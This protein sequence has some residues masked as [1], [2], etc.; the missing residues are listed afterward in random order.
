MGRVFRVVFIISFFLLLAT[1]ASAGPYMSWGQWT[2]GNGDAFSRCWNRAGGALQSV[3]LTP[4][5]NGRF[6]HGSN[7]VF[8]A[9]VICYDLGNRFIVTITVAAE[10]GGVSNMTTDAVRDRINAYIF[11][12]GVATCSSVAGTWHWWNDTTVVFSPDGTLHN[13]TGLTGTWRYEN[14]HALASWS[15]GVQGD[16]TLGPDWKTMSETYNGETKTMTHEC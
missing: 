4:V 10:R 8:T 13:N 1:P 11:G 3:G 14:G 2:S 7:D 15:N 6:F 12:A 16:Y 5:Q 9:S